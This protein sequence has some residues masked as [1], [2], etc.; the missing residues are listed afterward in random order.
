MV[1]NNLSNEI[2]IIRTTLTVL[3]SWRHLISH[4][5]KV[6]DW[7]REQFDPVSD[8]K[9]VIP[10]EK[11]LV[12]FANKHHYN[13]SIREFYA[14]G[15]YEAYD[16]VMTYAEKAKLNI[17][18]FK[19]KR[20]SGRNLINRNFPNLGWICTYCNR[21]FSDQDPIPCSQNCCKSLFC[22]KNCFD[23]HSRLRFKHI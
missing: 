9:E 8:D 5:T 13:D 4:L 20:N 2:V 17:R 7:Q 10:Y 1:N 6:R 11:W 18:W 12:A 16:M 23:E 21:S 3:Y 15:Y 14:Q 19:E 22:S